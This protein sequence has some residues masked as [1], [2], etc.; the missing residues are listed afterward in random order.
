MESF[1]HQ[2]ENTNGS[3]FSSYVY[4]NCNADCVTPHFHKNFELLLVK[5]GQCSFTIG[6]DT[7]TVSEGEAILVLPFQV[8]RFSASPDAQ[9]R[10]VTFN[11]LLIL[12]LARGLENKKLRCP[13]FRPSKN[14]FC[15]FLDVMN[16]LFGSVS[17]NNIEL[18]SAKRMKV[19]GCLYLIGGEILEQTEPMDMG[20]SDVVILD[21]VEYIADNFR[22]DLTLQT[23]AKDKGYNY[24]Y[25]SRCF[26]R[27]FGISFKTMLNQYRTNY[28][29]SL[30]RDTRLSLS[31]IAFESGFQS[32]R[33]FDHVFKS[34]FGI[35]PKDFRKNK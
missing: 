23:V 5:N 12:T 17:S 31:E 15:T 30:L 16:E 3:E 9:F 21:I 27:T 8:H 6:G 25:L 34:T 26:N 32:I 19:K 1:Y 10:S 14:T 29:L 24:Q 33:S 20:S 28:A 35:P 7:F 11:E 18:P 13:V 22:S 2:T 4:P